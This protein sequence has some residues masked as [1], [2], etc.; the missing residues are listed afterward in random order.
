MKILYFDFVCIIDRMKRK[1]VKY[2]PIIIQRRSHVFCLKFYFPVVDIFF[3]YQVKI[4][5]YDSR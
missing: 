3:Y 1:A 2:Q 4:I 5:L